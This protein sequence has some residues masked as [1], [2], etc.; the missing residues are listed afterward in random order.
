MSI[1]T[2]IN[3]IFLKSY[4]KYHSFQVRNILVSFLYLIMWYNFAAWWRP[5]FI[6]LS[7]DV[8]TYPGL[9]TISG[10]TFLICHWNHCHNKWKD[11]PESRTV[12]IEISMVSWNLPNCPRQLA[13]ILKDIVSSKGNQLFAGSFHVINDEIEA[14]IP[15]FAK[16]WFW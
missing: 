16:K 12:Y 1:Q 5:F 3:L 9:K 15:Q 6:L 7:G 11:N 13:S 10:Q 2:I 8:K 14:D 4:Y